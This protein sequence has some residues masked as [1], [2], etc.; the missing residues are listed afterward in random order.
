VTVPEP[1]V[2]LRP[3]CDDDYDFFARVYASTREE[4]LAAAPLTQEQKAAFLAQQFAAQTEHYAKHYADAVFDVIL[5]DGEPAGRLIVG[6]WERE[7][8]IADIALLP[9]YRGTGVGTRLLRSLIDE[10][11]DSGRRLT[12]HVEHA[13]PAMRLYERLGFAA[14]ED[15]GVY[16]MLERTPARDQAKTAS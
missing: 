9:D 4:E 6:R 12:I 15:R 11:E 2:A 7:I 14:V 8:R 10:S 3:A 13:N 5:V 16:L 1:G